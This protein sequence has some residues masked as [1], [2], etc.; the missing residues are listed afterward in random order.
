MND[1]LNKILA[2]PLHKFLGVTSISSEAGRGAFSIT[3][4]DNVINSAGILHGGV[5]YALCDVCAYGGLVSLLDE[6][7]EA[8]THDIQISIMRSAKFA[9][10]VD[11]QSEVIK[12]GKSIC[13]IDVQVTVSGEVIASARVTKSMR[14]AR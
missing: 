13:F 4:T 11:F 14:E 12:R 2:H 9:D 10:V 7:T 1:R 3:L 6:R 8:V 5:I